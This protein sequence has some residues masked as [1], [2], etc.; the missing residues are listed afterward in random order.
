[1]DFFRFR[2]KHSPLYSATRVWRNLVTLLVFKSPRP[3]PGITRY[4]SSTAY[5]PAFCLVLVLSVQPTELSPQVLPERTHPEMTMD[6]RS[7]YI[8]FATKIKKWF[9]YDLERESCFSAVYMYMQVLIF[10][11]HHHDAA[12]TCMY[13]KENH[14]SVQ[15]TC[16]NIY[17][18]SSWCSV[19]LHVHVQVKP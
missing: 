1:M 11:C 16:T 8:L 18:S 6:S 3:G 13:M 2:K 12:L 9:T 19:N 4:S 14:A 7:G 15:C 5:S 10:I 17:L